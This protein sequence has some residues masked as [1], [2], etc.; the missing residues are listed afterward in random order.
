MT[1]NVYS[2]Y[3]VIHVRFY[4]ANFTKYFRD[5]CERTTKREVDFSQGIFQ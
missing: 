3:I 5:I 4:N 2:Q 1:R